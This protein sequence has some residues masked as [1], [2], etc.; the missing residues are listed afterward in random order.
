MISYRGGEMSIEQCFEDIF[1]IDNIRQVYSDKIAGKSAIGID[2]ICR[3]AFAEKKESEFSLISKKCLSGKYHFSPYLEILVLKGR[4]KYPR[5]LAIPTLRDQLTLVLLKDFLQETEC[6]NDVVQRELP[7]QIIQ[8][9]S[10]KRQEIR[11]QRKINKHKIFRTDITGFYDN[12]EREILMDTIREKILYPK[13]L[14]LIYKAIST[15][16]V[17]RDY[18]KKKISSY[19][20]AKGI[21]QG[22]A[23]SNIL[24]NIYLHKFDESMIPLSSGYFRYVDDILIF[25]KSAK[26]NMIERTLITKLTALGLSINREKTSLVP[27]RK[28][29]DFLGYVFDKKTITVRESTLERFIS[30]LTS[31]FANEKTYMNS[32]LEIYK[33]RAYRLY[34]RDIQIPS[35]TEDIYKKLFIERINLKITGA[36]SKDEDTGNYKRYGWLFYF[37]KITDMKM[38]AV[39]DNIIDRLFIQSSLFNH[40]K[41]PEVKSIRKAFYI[42]THRQS[43]YYDGYVHNYASYDSVEKKI[44]Y[45][46]YRAKFEN[47]AYSE[48][49]INVLFEVTKQK[50]LKKMYIDIGMLS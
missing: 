40:T 23:I 21:P 42:I 19:T 50:E 4:N 16:I 22:L 33:E 24:S 7:N 37:V 38:L 31:M 46:Q 9:V 27:M 5:I 29:Y 41:P 47:K 1:L 45:L 25:H 6:F 30:S 3:S 49:E 35:M 2:G 13:A 44:K 17:P 28:R 39:I 8:K 14:T 48:E 20:T 10:Q 34:G 26:S 15:P 32:I 12:I 36:I 11:A 43:T 18:K